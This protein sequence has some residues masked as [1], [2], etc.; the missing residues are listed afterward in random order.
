MLLPEKAAISK[1]RT[2]LQT[3]EN[4]KRGLPPGDFGMSRDSENIKSFQ[5]VLLN[6]RRG[7]P[8]RSFYGL[9]I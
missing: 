8:V 1:K 2:I 9:S 4:F 7:A 6:S 5:D 3:P